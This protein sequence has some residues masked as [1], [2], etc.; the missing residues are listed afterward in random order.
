MNDRVFSHMSEILVHMNQYLLGFARDYSISVR[1]Q[2]EIIT[3][4][5]P[6]KF[7]YVLLYTLLA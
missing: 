1:R 6:W 7:S 4:Q 2:F 3:N 5:K